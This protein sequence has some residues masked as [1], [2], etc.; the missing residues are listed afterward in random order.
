MK[1]SELFIAALK[2]GL[3]AVET[4][5]CLPDYEPRY[6]HR[7]P[8]EVHRAALQEGWRFFPVSYSEHFAVTHANLHQATD[9]VQQLSKWARESPNWALV[10]GSQSCVFVLEVDGGEGVST[11]TRPLRRRLEL[12]R[13]A[14]LHS[15]REALHLLR[16]ARGP[17]ANQQRSADRQRSECPR[18]RRLDACSALPRAAWHPA[19]LPEPGGRGGRS[20]SMAS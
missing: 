6:I 10:T 19:L 14:S 18:R 8:V 9:N 13:H 17:Q 3:S 1:S 15:R 11:T 12:A 7:V 16:L 20:A 4:L 2:Q 5:H